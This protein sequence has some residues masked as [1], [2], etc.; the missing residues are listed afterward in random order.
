[1]KKIFKKSNIFAFIIGALIFGS[2]GVVSAYTIFANDIG[3]TPSDT[4]WDVDNVKDAIDDLYIKMINNPINI[5]DSN[6][7]TTYNI[8]NGVTK[9]YVLYSHSTSFENLNLEITGNIILSTNQ[10][11]K[12]TNV[13]NYGDT[14]RNSLS[15]IELDLTGD[16]GT[17]SLSV[18]GGGGAAVKI[19]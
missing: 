15:I 6:N 3:Y 9:A 2:I 18:S 19:G 11:Y 17:I 4:T 16:S 14:L 10:I 7:R 8:P 5:I 13:D 12:N 1:M